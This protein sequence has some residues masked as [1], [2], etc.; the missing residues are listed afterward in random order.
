MRTCNYKVRPTTV[1]D[2]QHLYGR[3]PPRTAQ[4]FTIEVDGV[5]HAIAGIY[6]L[7]HTAQI[8]SDIKAPVPRRSIIETCRVMMELIKSK[9]VG[10]QAL[11][12][13]D[14][15]TSLNMM[16]HFGFEHIAT[17]PEGEV[18]AWHS[19]QQRSHT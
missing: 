12:D 17:A 18:Y 13:P 14:S 9:G 16:R 3:L 2:Y 5:P 7:S 15:P 6:M 11:R 4:G 19:W 10:A 1:E 8:F